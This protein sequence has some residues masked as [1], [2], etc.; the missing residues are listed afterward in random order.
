MILYVAG[1]IKTPGAGVAARAGTTVHKQ[2]RHA[3]RIAGLVDIDFMKVGNLKLVAL[4]RFYFRIEY[5]HRYM[6]PKSA[7]ATMLG[8]TWID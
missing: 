6:D 3:I 5:V 4:V 2:D 7:L 1:I 8:Q